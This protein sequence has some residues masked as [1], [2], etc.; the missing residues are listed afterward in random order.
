MMLWPLR[1]RPA[2][3]LAVL[4]RNGLRRWTGC[5]RNWQTYRSIPSPASARP[6]D[7]QGFS[8]RTVR[9]RA[10]KE[11]HVIVQ[12]S[13]FGGGFIWRLPKPGTDA[14]SLACHLPCQNPKSDNIGTHGTI[15]FSGEKTGKMDENI[16][17]P[18]RACQ[19]YLSGT[20]DENEHQEPE[21]SD[22]E[23]TEIMASAEAFFDAEEAE[24]DKAERDGMQQE[25]M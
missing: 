3:A 20:H 21:Y 25:G 17:P 16:T 19:N 8:W 10:S 5:K 1:M 15:A 2:T 7:L 24:H 9:L 4:M 14:S 18:S 12:R 22:A 23:L 11:L 13:S 6:R